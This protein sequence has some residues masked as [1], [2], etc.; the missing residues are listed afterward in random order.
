ME[1]KLSGSFGLSVSIKK[2]N[3]RH[4]GGMHTSSEVGG[5]N[6][7]CA[8]PIQGV[9][10]TICLPLPSGWQAD[11]TGANMSK[12]Q[13]TITS[14]NEMRSVMRV[15]QGIV[16]ELVHSERRG[17]RVTV[18]TVSLRTAAQN[19]RMWAMLH[20]ISQ[21]VTW[22][23]RKLTRQEWKDVLSASLKLEEAVPNI[24]GTGFVVL[25]QHTH[26]M[27]T[28]E[29]AAL[30]ELIEA[31]GVQQGVQFTWPASDDLLPEQTKLSA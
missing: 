17:V 5:K 28:K 12:R 11:R 18:Q 9:K 19:R 3:R 1:A 6:P 13:F 4:C 23:G 8:M 16:S 27:S 30:I 25:G 10:A 29:M 7:S 20:D 24:E 31:F 15:V 14:P 2:H 26:E 21:Q 22:Y